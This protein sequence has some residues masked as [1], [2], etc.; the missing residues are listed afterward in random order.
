MKNSK[1]IEKSK[2][3]NSKKNSKLN[4]IKKFGFWGFMF[5][6]AKGIVWLGIFF[7]VGSLFV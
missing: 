6:L 2:E 3:L 5:F 1:N 7:G 4:L